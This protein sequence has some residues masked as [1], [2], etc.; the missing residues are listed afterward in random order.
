MYACGGG[1]GGW[2]QVTLWPGL[3]ADLVNA[4]A[5]W[6]DEE[7]V[8]DHGLVTSRK[9]DELPVFSG[10]EPSA[11][12][13]EHEEVTDPRTRELRFDIPLLASRL[14]AALDWVERE[15]SAATL[16]VGCFGATQL[17]GEPG[18]LD[19]VADLA[20]SGSLNI[21]PTVKRW[22]VDG[23]TVCRSPRGWPRAR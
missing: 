5:S 7:V 1:G 17:F 18:A 12:L 23:G 2:P 20:C 19:T 4:G 11:L 21:Y 16:P 9:P 3:Q 6:V 10:G 15:P 22:E 8:V 13:Q 14:I